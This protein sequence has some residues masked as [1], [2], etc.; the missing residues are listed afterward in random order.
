MAETRIL[1]GMELDET[2][3]WI[4]SD[5]GGV[6][7]F[8]HARLEFGGESFSIADLVAAAKAHAESCSSREKA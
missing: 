1:A 5:A 8:N 6:D 7:T 4:V 3:P 2:T